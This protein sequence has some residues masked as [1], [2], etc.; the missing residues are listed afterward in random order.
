M[1]SKA[2]AEDSMDID[3]MDID[4]DPIFID[5]GSMVK[6]NYSIPAAMLQWPAVLI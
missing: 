3:L 2:S 5:N 4:N 1:A 6:Y